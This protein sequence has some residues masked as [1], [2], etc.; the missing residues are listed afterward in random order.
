MILSCKYIVYALKQNASPKK[1]P[2]DFL[3]T[4]L[5]LI[6]M[7]YF[8]GGFRRIESFIKWGDMRINKAN[9]G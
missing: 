5:P 6:L 9:G 7:R 8:S 1:N 3:R 4:F 2:S